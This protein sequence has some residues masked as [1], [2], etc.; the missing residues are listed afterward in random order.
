MK[1]FLMIMMI[2]ILK[3]TCPSIF[4]KDNKLIYDRIL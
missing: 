2:L 3:I 4:E 1:I